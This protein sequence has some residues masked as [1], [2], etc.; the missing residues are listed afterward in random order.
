MAPKRPLVDPGME[1]CKAIKLTP[2]KPDLCLV[3]GL[4]H[5]F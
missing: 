5:G 4:A 3:C 1:P 2:V